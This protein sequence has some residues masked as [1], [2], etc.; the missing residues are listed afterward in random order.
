MTILKSFQQLEIHLS[1]WKSHLVLVVIVT[2]CWHYVENKCED[3][4]LGIDYD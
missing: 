1:K 3:S 2:S 4:L